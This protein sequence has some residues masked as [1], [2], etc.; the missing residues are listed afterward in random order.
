MT[1][2]Y[3]LSYARLDEGFALQFADD[4]V[5]AGMSMWVDQYDI[6]PSQPWDRAVETA[7]RGCGGLIV[8]LSPRSVASPNVA[9]EVGVA[10]DG[11]KV[12]IPVLMEPCVL[13]LRLTRIQFIDASRDY[14]A[15]LVRVLATVGGK[16]RLD[17]TSEGA[18]GAL[19]ETVLAQAE[20]RLTAIVGPIAHVLVRKAALLA[21]SEAGL[22]RI[23]ASGLDDPAQRTA[24]LGRRVGSTAQPPTNTAEPSRAG[25][26]ASDL[27]AIV[28]AL[29]RHVGPIARELVRREGAR[30]T[31]RQDLCSRLAGHIVSPHE[32]AA[33]LGELGF[34]S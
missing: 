24:M 21:R 8:I 34:G 25:P 29:N 7:V 9:D 30:A 6:P 26:E 13:P 1:T 20:R 32:R 22:Y 27:D 3:F 16:S 10:L 28:R 14:E 15:A 19:E 5:A 23:L 2:T 33:F 4:L 11:G 31:S 12:L 18:A 17:E